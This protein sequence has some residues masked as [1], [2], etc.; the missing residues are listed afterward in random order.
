[1]VA[2]IP[3]LLLVYRTPSRNWDHTR[4]DPVAGARAGRR[5]RASAT[6]TAPNDAAFSRKA[7]PGPSVPSTMPPSAGPSAREALNCA[8]FR[9]TALSS[10]ERGTSSLTNACH[11]GMFIPATRPLTPTRAT[12]AAGEASPAAHTAQRLTAT[13]AWTDW[14]TISTR[15]RAKRSATAPAT[16][17]ASTV[18]MSCMNAARPT[19]AAL[20]VSS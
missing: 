8:E 6:S 12:R 9:V 7:A 4:S 13:R 17:P 10:A 11:D 19:H 3:G 5:M 16:G 15:R 14:V 1:M 2:R 18:G 20:E